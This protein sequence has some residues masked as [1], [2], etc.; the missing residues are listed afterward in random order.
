MKLKT[1]TLLILAAIVM[2]SIACGPSSSHSEYQIPTSTPMP[3]MKQRI[4]WAEYYMKQT[5]EAPTITVPTRTPY[6]K[7]S[8]TPRIVTRIIT[9]TPTG[10]PPKHSEAEVIA[11]SKAFLS[12]W[13]ANTMPEGS[14]NSLYSQM[15]QWTATWNGAVDR[16]WFIEGFVPTTPVRYQLRLF[17]NSGAIELIGGF[18]GISPPL[19]K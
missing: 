6:I 5:K 19:V 17:E 10:P 1:L 7:P 14:L 13:I 8:P 4:E 2:A 16:T 15:G 12:N 11:L 18:D 3:P 9:P